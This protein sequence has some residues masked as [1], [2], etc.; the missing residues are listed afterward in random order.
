MAKWLS[1][2]HDDIIHSDTRSLKIFTDLRDRLQWSTWVL[3]LNVKSS[4][5]WRHD[6]RDWTADVI[7][8]V[9][10]CEWKSDFCLKSRKV[11]SDCSWSRNIQRVCVCLSEGRGGGGCQRPV[12]ESF[13][14][15]ESCQNNSVWANSSAERWRKTGPCA[16]LRCW[17][18]D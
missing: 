5:E 15:R 13:S 18:Q 8:T 11:F 1:L 2:I 4:Q 12:K 16:I 14:L 3:L 6:D 17:S 7:N 9:F 10:Y